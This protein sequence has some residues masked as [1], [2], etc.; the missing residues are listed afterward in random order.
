MTTD[1]AVHVVQMIVEQGKKMSEIPFVDDPEI[2]TKVSLCCAVCCYF[3]FM[4][5]S[6]LIM[7]FRSV[8]LTLRLE[9][10]PSA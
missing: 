9:A 4:S 5:L 1:T 2:E 10:R 8:L 7:T 6:I 3:L